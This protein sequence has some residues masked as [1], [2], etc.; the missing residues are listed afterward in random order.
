MSERL[1]AAGVQNARMEDIVQE[2]FLA[3][4]E[5]HF[6]QRVEPPNTE[7]VTISYLDQRAR[8][9]STVRVRQRFE[10]PPA[11]TEGEVVCVCARGY[12][13][14]NSVWPYRIPRPIEY[15]MPGEYR[16]AIRNSPA[17]GMAIQYS[18]AQGIL[19]GHTVFPSHSEE[20]H[21]CFIL[22]QPWQPVAGSA[23]GLR[24]ELGGKSQVLRRH[25]GRLKHCMPFL[26]CCLICSWCC[27]LV[28]ELGEGRAFGVGVS[29]PSP[30][31]ICFVAC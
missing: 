28:H 11:V 8:G 17:Q 4:A 20:V 6:V 5:G 1:E 26:L 10:L 14:G 12:G 19:Y 25:E 31:P 2:Q 13:P 27:Q 3:L 16:M 9:G 15:R 23:R 18:P 22:A 21:F 24:T 7:L 29:K 30:S